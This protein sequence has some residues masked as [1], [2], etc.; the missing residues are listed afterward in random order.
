MGGK[1]KGDNLMTW[2]L[3]FPSIGAV[4]FKGLSVV[5]MS[6][7][8]SG[9]AIHYQDNKYV[10]KSIRNSFS[11]PNHYNYHDVPVGYTRKIRRTKA[12]HYSRRGKPIGWS[13]CLLILWFHKGT[14]TKSK[15][16]YFN[17]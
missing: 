8:C 1:E 17:V 15:G 10:G 12:I 13:R 2:S 16:E 5:G 11:E 7:F 6:K 4:H 9:N 14:I 3:I